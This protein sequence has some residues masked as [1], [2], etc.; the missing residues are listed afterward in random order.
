MKKFA[1][2]SIVL[3]FVLNLNAQMKTA[4]KEDIERFF[5]SK[6]YIVLED[7]PF[8]SFNDYVKNNFKN[9]WTLTPFEI[10]DLQTYETK[11]K[12]PNSSFMLIA[13]ARFSESSSAM[14]RSNSD[15]LSDADTY[16][17]MIIDVVMGHKT[18][19]INQMPD[20]VTVPVCFSEVED[21]ESYEYK[22]GVLIQFIQF[23]IKYCR[24]NP[25]NDIRDIIKENEGQTKNYEL[26]L[27]KEELAPEVNTLEKIKAVYPFT[28]KLTTREEIQKAITERNPKV[29]I[30]HKVGPEGSVPG[31][32]KCW[33]FIITAAEG[34][35]L[36]FNSHKISA[37]KPD[38][39]L[40][41]DFKEIAK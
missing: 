24:D 36:Y 35:P 19:N 37:K 6:T 28:V 7:D 26:W 33:N 14:F 30:L 12:D 11:C 31:D 23:Y 20:L 15:I 13:I 9:V 41:D 3:M 27:V 34:K 4:G 2:L 16:D 40:E 18:G 38:A 39:F 17:Y 25:G 5:N 1:V 22:M 29:A 10:I 8:S 32:A 21:Y